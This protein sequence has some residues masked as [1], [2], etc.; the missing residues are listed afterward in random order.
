[1]TRKI[2]IAII[3]LITVSRVS[4]KYSLNLLGSNPKIRIDSDSNINIVELGKSLSKDCDVIIY[5][6]D[7]YKPTNSNNHMK[8]LKIKYL[9]TRLCKIFSPSFLPFTPQLYQEI[10]DNEYDIILTTEF[11][12][13]G[14]ILSA[15]A[16]ILNMKKRSKIFVSNLFLLISKYIQDN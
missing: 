5:I 8:N 13:F 10:K 16:I 9:P 7:V 3:N 12:Q 6:S 14:T 15:L 1:M 4:P 2:K 11:F